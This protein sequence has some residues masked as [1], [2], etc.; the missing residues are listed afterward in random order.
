MS[1]RARDI[2]IYRR[3]ERLGHKLLTPEERLNLVKPYLPPPTK[4]R[5]RTDPTV[6]R[7]R[8]SDKSMLGVRRFLR[9]QFH[10]L[11]Y[12]IIH[13]FFS[14]YIRL[15]Q[16]YHAVAYRLHSVVYHHHRTPAYIRN[17][18]KGL[19]RLP[20]H[21][22]VILTLEDHRR[23]GAGLEKLIDEVA[24]IAAWCA[25]AG[26]PQ[27]SVYEKTGI[28]KGFLPQTHTAVASRLGAYFGP[29]FP[30]VDVAAPHTPPVESTFTPYNPAS[31]GDSGSS[32]NSDN[33]DDEV[34]SNNSNSSAS[35]G[36]DY[37][38]QHLS[39]LLISAEDGRD[40]MVDLTKTL[41]EMAQRKKL[42]TADVTM[43]LVDAELTESV[44]SEPDLLV[45][46]GPHVELAGYPPWQIRLTEIFHMQ[47]NH[48]VGYQ[49]F[50]KA[51]HKFAQAQ[52]RKGR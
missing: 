44:M 34:G 9:R 42:S 47:D 22:S 41:A 49:V 45:L 31:S 30:S 14:L 29:K 15:R 21:L 52:M 20:K 26:I 39:I 4:F 28:L 43:E 13:A 5:Q 2:D 10:L 32:S 18:V 27:L 17:D 33:D 3:D 25:S 12:L 19:K 35:N 51:L 23:S 48:G 36:E 7:T 24:D 46:F 50:S 8:E 16:A 38:K 1:F 6:S 37:S 11:V 40:S